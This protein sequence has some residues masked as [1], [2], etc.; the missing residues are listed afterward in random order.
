MGPY[1][2]PRVTGGTKMSANTH[3]ITLE[4]CCNKGTHST[5]SLS[6]LSKNIYK[7]MYI[8]SCF[9]GGGLDLMG[10]NSIVRLG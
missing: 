4:T 6:N 8:L 3:L 2:K 9:R 10:K 5:T 1:I 7:S